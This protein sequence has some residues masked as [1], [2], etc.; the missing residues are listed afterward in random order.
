MAY[1]ILFVN[2]N[3]LKNFSIIYIESKK[4]ENGMSE[5]MGDMIDSFDEIS[6]EE[7]EDWF[8]IIDEETIY[9]EGNY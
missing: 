1:F 4:G 6:C 2:L 3:F 9:E 8:A 5:W 7:F